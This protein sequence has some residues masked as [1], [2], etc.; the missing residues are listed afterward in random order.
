MMRKILFAFIF[1][2]MAGSA[3]AA[4]KPSPVFCNQLVN[5]TPDA[6]VAY[7]PGIDVNGNKVA[8]ADLPSNNA[9]KMPDK[10]QIP[11]TVN[12]AQA[13]HFD[14]ST[15]PF[16]QLGAGTEGVI[17][18]LTVEGNQVSFNGQPIGDEQ[19]RQL[20]VLCMQPR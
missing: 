10:I 12:L 16:N 7:Q 2:C 18:M 14:T 11:L 15:Y 3:H 4:P 19:Q 8:P 17:G 20:A 6:N 13:A 5:A 1:A 9:I